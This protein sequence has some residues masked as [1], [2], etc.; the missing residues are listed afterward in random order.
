MAIPEAYL[1][2]MAQ[3]GAQKTSTDTYGT[4]KLALESGRSPLDADAVKQLAA[5][6]SL[7]ELRGK[8][9]GLLQA[10]AAKIAS[11]LQAPGGQLARVFSAYGSKDSSGQQAA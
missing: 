1:T 5:L 4:M 9:V 8:I 3:I 6:P 2:T 10:P 11:V 7:N